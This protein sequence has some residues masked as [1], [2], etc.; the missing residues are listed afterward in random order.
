M[1]Y[2]KIF[3]FAFIISYSC[4]QNKPGS[5]GENLYSIKSDSTSG[6]S[7]L[8]LID[9][10]LFDFKVIKLGEKITHVFRFRNSGEDS[11][12]IN[13]VSATCGCTVAS[14]PKIKI[15]PNGRDS[16][17]AF[18]DSDLSGKGIQNKV[19][20]VTSNAISSPQLLTLVGT[21]K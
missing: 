14:F 1:R 9:S 12:L 21:V 18:F 13:S 2:K 15:A 8:E 17:I 6:K 4:S 19:I 5:N 10:S 20:T 3:L 11:L 7:N 16:I